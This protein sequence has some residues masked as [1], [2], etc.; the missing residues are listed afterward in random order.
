MSFSKLSPATI[1][2]SVDEQFSSPFSLTQMK[3]QLFLIL[4]SSI[5]HIM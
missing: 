1:T 4:A 3:V 5:C 2:K